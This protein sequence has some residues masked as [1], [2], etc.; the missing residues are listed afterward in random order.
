MTTQE[1]FGPFI[2]CG[3]FALMASFATIG[4]RATNRRSILT[5]DGASSAFRR[6]PVDDARKRFLMMHGLA[7]FICGG[8]VGL[9]YASM[10]VAPFNVAGLYAVS[11]LVGIVANP[12]VLKLEGIKA[13][14]IMNAIK[15]YLHWK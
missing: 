1:I 11:G 7:P 2:F 9:I 6:A 10:S 13:Q 12:M 14:T 5:V 4:A 3:L 15:K 8:L